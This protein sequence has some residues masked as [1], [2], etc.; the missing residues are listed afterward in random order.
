MATALQPEE[1]LI[2]AIKLG[3]LSHFTADTPFLHKTIY[4][5]RK[6]PIYKELLKVFR[7]SGSPAAPFS[8]VLDVA[9]FNLQFGNKLRRYNPDLVVYD[10]TDN[11]NKY[12]DERVLPKLDKKSKELLSGIAAKLAQP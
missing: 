2:G 7:F 11:A 10:A 9:L 3:E 8:E 4:K 12:F 1:I 5:L 6:D